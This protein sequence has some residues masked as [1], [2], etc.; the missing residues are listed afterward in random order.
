MARLINEPG[1]LQIPI[2]IVAMGVASIS[3]PLNWNQP[4]WQWFDSVIPV[5]IAAMMA[6]Y[7]P[8]RIQAAR[9]AQLY[10]AGIYTNHIKSWLWRAVLGVGLAMLF[11]AHSWHW[12]KIINLSLF[13]AFWWWIV[14]NWTLNAKRGKPRFYVLINTKISNLEKGFKKHPILLF[15]LQ[16]I[17]LL[18]TGY[19]YVINN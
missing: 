14:F 9:H 17:G 10:E 4:Q 19:V 3:A 5:L 11:H 6:T 16:C 1:F 8:I 13:I 15:I 7:L 12:D 18:V 2:G